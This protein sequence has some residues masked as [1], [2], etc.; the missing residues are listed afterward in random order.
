M[1]VRRA[2]RADVDAIVAMGLRF[3]ADSS[4]A[5]YLRATA[6][7]MRALT[8]A[9]ISNDAS[10]LFVAEQDDAIIGMIAATL[11]ANPM[12]GELVGTEVVWWMDPEARGGRTALR[13]VRA[14]E[15]WARDCGAVVFQMAAPTAKV[16]HFYGVLGYDAIETHYQRRLA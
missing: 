1:T 5:A 11:C 2:T 13:L 16:G 9:V 14:A 8:L 15:N 4:Y 12:S 10:V 3:Q 7:T 6:E